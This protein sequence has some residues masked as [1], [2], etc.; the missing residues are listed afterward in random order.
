LRATIARLGADRF[1]FVAVSLAVFGK[2]RR[3]LPEAQ[4]ENLIFSLGEVRKRLDNHGAAL[5]FEAARSRPESELRRA[6]VQ[7]RCR[8]I[9]AV[10]RPIGCGKSNRFGFSFHL[11]DLRYIDFPT[12]SNRLKD[13]AGWL[14]CW[15][16][17]GTSWA[18]LIQKMPI[19]CQI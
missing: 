5:Q 18:G 7:A 13:I 9:S 15:I 14:D 4:G 8:K 1:T 11:D 2:K 6:R 19:K 17:P 16:R 10:H 3:R 12:F